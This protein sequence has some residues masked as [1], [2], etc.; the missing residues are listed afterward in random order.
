M[1]IVFEKQYLKDLYE[2]GGT[3]KKKYKFQPE[4]INRY[5]QKID[6][7]K[8]VDNIMQLKDFKSLRY[9]KLKGNK[10]G[11]ESIRINKAYR[12]EFMSSIQSDKITICSIIEL[13]NHY[14]GQ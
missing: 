8:A 10:K 14:E 3:Q 1:E 13:S 4:V 12:I 9:E 11:L 5:V 2:K 7:L 6:I